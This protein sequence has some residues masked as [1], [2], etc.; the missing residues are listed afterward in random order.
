MRRCYAAWSR[1][2]HDILVRY[3]NT[4]LGMF[5]GHTHQDEFELYYRDDARTAAAVVNYVGPSATPLTNFNPGFRVYEVDW[6]TLDVVDTYTYVANLTAANEVR[7][8]RHRPPRGTQ[9]EGPT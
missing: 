9:N 2:F 4:V 7:G 3:E 8:R 6:D 1:N 5:T